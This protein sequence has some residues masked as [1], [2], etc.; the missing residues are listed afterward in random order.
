MRYNK[1][2]CKKECDAYITLR[3]GGPD[4]HAFDRCIKDCDEHYPQDVPHDGASEATANGWYI[5][6]DPSEK[7]ALHILHTSWPPVKTNYN[8]RRLSYRITPRI[9]ANL[10]QMPDPTKTYGVDD[11]Q[12][13]LGCNPR[14]K[15]ILNDS[16]LQWLD[17]YQHIHP[18]NIESPLKIGD[19]MA[20]EL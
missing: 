10:D 8:E 2:L 15:F 11:L 9:A 17:Q 16:T 12:L 6:I 4:R 7:N 18:F 14:S 13:K 20:R 19:K 5:D 1:D 3:P